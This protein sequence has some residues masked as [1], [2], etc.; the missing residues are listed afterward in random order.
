MVKISQDKRLKIGPIGEAVLASVAVVGIV[1]VAGLFPGIAVAIAPFIKKKKYSPKQATEKTI[2]SLIRNG[3][4]KKTVTQGGEVRV[5][6]TKKGKWEVLLR[7]HSDKTSS[8]VWDGVWRIVIFD[9]P[10]TK[11]NIRV[12]LRRAMRL[13]G[14]KMLQQSVWVYPY[15]C[16]DFIKVVKSHLGVSNDVLYIKTNYIENDKHLRKEFLL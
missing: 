2:D 5:E 6:L 15:P 8:V 10:Q 1:T 14:F 13:F 11:A 3:L 12:E 9:V 7:S 16:D 4:L